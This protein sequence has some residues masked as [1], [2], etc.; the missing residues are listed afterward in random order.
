MTALSTWQPYAMGVVSLIALTLVQS[1]YQASPLAASTPVM[2]AANPIVGIAIGL[3]LFDESLAISGWHLPGAMIGVALLA[4]GVTLLD[5]SPLVL[6]IQRLEDEEHGRR[7]S[8]ALEDAPVEIQL[9]LQNGQ[10][11]QGCAGGSGPGDPIVGM[12]FY[13][14][15]VDVGFESVMVAA[16]GVQVVFAGGATVAVVRR[17]GDGVV[18]IGVGRTLPAHRVSAVDVTEPDELGQSGRCGVG[19]PPVVEQGRASCRTR[20]PCGSSISTT[21]ASR[22]RNRA[23]VCSPARGSTRSSNAPRSSPGSR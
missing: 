9:A 23:T 2:D 14:P 4:I 3:A 15:A 20:A 18:Q 10:L 16:T 12:L 6:R 21:R 11:D 8:P 1:A 19:G 7:A 13:L 5:T 22:A 17:V